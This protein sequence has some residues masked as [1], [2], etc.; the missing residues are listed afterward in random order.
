MALAS[1]QFKVEA[2]TRI[3]G[4][5]GVP[6]VE[7]LDREQ[8]PGGSGQS[9]LAVTNRALCALLFLY[10]FF[11]PPSSRRHGVPCRALQTGQS[12][13]SIASHMSRVR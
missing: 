13:L 8:V 2:R 5:Y 6:G 9:F 12:T 1:L 3:A 4:E 11:S 10:R 7:S